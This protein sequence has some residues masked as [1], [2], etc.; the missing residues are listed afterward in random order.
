M[1][2]KFSVSTPT[3]LTQVTTPS[4]MSLNR[5]IN[6]V[7]VFFLFIAHITLANESYCMHSLLDQ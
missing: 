5:I 7:G 4:Y 6:N 2:G 1:V 3:I